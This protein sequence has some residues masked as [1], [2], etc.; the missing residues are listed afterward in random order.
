MLIFSF[1]RSMSGNEIKIFM[2]ILLNCNERYEYNNMESMMH[3]GISYPTILACLKKLSE[4]GCIKKI[5][6]TNFSIL[7]VGDGYRSL[8]DHLRKC[9]DDLVLIPEEPEPVKEKKWWNREHMRELIGHYAHEQAVPKEKFKEWCRIN[10]AK[11][12]RAAESLLDYC[13]NIEAAKKTITNCR[14]DRAKQKLDW[15]LGGD[16]LRNIQKYAPKNLD[17]SGGKKWH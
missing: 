16:V 9:P 4:K 2:T 15:S 12:I 3:D 10:F 13:G 5:D 7:R 17:Q 8:V 11:N 14:I 6:T 1:I